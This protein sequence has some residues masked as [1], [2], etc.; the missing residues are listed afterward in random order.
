M[1]VENEMKHP[2]HL[3]NRPGLLYYGMIVVVLLNTLVGFFGYLK[4][5]G[6]SEAVISLN[7]PDDW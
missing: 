4:Y 7:L 1:P 6:A 2:K 5:G 3:T